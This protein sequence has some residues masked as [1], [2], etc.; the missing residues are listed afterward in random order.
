MSR[1]LRL[2]AVAAEGALADQNTDHDSPLEG[3]QF[4]HRQQFGSGGGCCFTVQKNV[5]PDAGRAG[6]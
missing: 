5:K 6:P 3:A 1:H 4:L 2:L